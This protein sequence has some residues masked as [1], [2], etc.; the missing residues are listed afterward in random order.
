VLRTSIHGVGDVA[1][2]LILFGLLRVLPPW[3][4]VAIAA[5]AGTIAF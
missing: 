2:A 5:A 1:Y 4:V 3:A